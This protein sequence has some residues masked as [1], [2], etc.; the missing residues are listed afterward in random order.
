M[1]KKGKKAKAKKVIL[2]LIYGLNFDEHVL[3]GIKVF[4][5]NTKECPKENLVYNVNKKNF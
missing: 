5:E 1:N 4:C 2:A 3:S